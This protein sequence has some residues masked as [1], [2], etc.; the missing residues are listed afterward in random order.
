[1]TT[2]QLFVPLA[3]IGVAVVVTSPASAASI[4]FQ[5]F[6]GSVILPGGAGPTRL[7]VSA[8]SDVDVVPEPGTLVLIGVGLLGFGI[9]R[10]PAKQVPRVREQNRNCF[11]ITR[12]RAREV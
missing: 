2:R 8:Q 3:L 6:S 10:R 7:T 12:D 5:V 9:L 11:N 4:S 1:M